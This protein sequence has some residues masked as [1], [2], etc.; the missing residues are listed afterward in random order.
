[1]QT[2]RVQSLKLR[3]IIH[4]L[5]ILLPVTLLLAYQSWMDLRRAEVVDQAFQLASDAKQA[6]ERYSLFM[7]GVTDAVD[8]G[9]VG[10]G[11]L[12]ALEQTSRAVREIADPLK[13]AELATLNSAIRSVADA[14]SND[15]S[16]SQ[17][18]ARRDQIR[19]LDEQL[20]SQAQR[21]DNAAAA[22]I[23]GSIAAARAQ[24]RV[25]FGAASFTLLAAAFFLRGMIKRLT[26]PLARAVDTAQRI[27]RGDLSADPAQD[28]RDDLDGLLASLSRMERHLFESRRQIQQRTGELHY[29]TEQS[30]DLAEEAKAASRAKSQ[31]LA[32]MS[33]EIR[34]PMNG[35]LGMTELLLGT[36]LDSR[37]RR[38]TDTV[39]RSG[40][41]LLQIINDILDFSKIEAGKFELDQAEFS[42]RSV[43]EDAFELLAAHAHE[44][45]LE[46]I[47]QI[48]PDVPAMVVGDAGRVR[49]IITNVVGNSIKFTLSGE[50]EMRVSRIDT[51]DDPPSAMIG[52]CIRD[53]GIGMSEETLTKLFQAF[54]Q[55][56]GS[57]ARRYGGTGLGLVI[58][59]QLVEMM[60]GTMT[61]QSRLEVGSTFHFRIPLPTGSETQPL[62]TKPELRGKYALVVEDNPT[63]AAVIEGHLRLWGMRVCLAANGREG[64]QRLNQL[65]ADGER[66]DLALIDMKMPVMDGIEFVEALARMPQIAPAHLVMLTSVATDDDAR[67]ARAAGVDLYLAKPIRQQELLRAIQQL[68]E[69]APRSPMPVVP[70]GARIL[71]AE[72]NAV[73]QEVIKAILKN[74][75]CHT[76]M[77]ENGI[78]ALQA[79]SR[80][81]FDLVLMDCQMPEM[82]GF[83]AVQ[84]FRGTAAAR[85][86]FANKAD[87]PIIALT[88]NALV[89]DAARCVAAGFDD[90]LTKPFTWQQIDAVIRKWMPRTLAG[91][92]RDEPTP[93]SSDFIHLDAYDSVFDCTAPL[94][95]GR[96]NSD[97]VEGMFRESLDIYPVESGAL[98]ESLRAALGARN[99][100]A[101][102]LAA[103]RLRSCSANIG[104]FGLSRLCAALEPMAAESRFEEA[105]AQLAR[106]V[107]EQELVA[108]AVGEIVS[109]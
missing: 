44:K 102:S 56:N 22:A 94:R 75:G 70:I 82:D 109:A 103:H 17:A 24:S 90:Y 8:S 52:F 16:I 68:P 97:L 42:L 49:Q 31:F 26:Q 87:L 32:N 62:P 84:R 55:A 86:A 91:R 58:T 46:L 11:A 101:M 80:A 106:L 95:L 30:R 60:G 5:V 35:I 18:M 76:F 25:V 93:G 50:V 48:D 33:H 100:Q 20:R 10:R 104:A 37:Q 61:V 79:L 69:A 28:P 57:M 27:A 29:M 77:A 36:P 40:E 99:A 13:T 85:P 6:R 41:A 81:E 23:V 65:H 66:V 3:L 71:V 15:P 105:H 63:N 92:G 19:A 7:Q 1:M 89:G 54:T 83:E 108:A 53:T 64:L 78:D 67:R 51:A 21:Y 4:M 38:Y 59:Q 9:R 73:N 45:R 43:I 96:A 12:N 72:D 98:V 2:L 88:A 39:Y 107:A 74:L 34:T 47:C 14:L